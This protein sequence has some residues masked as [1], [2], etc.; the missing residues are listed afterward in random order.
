LVTV[1]A[2]YRHPSAPKITQKPS[3]ITRKNALKPPFHGGSRGSNP[4]RDAS[5]QP[6]HSFKNKPSALP[7]WGL[8]FCVWS[9]FG[10]DCLTYSVNSSI[11]N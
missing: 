1:F 2:N 9:R 5:L 3:K 4:L 11:L 6:N 10:H 8:F 7:G